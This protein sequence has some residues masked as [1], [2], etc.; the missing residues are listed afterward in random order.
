MH[1]EGSSETPCGNRGEKVKTMRFFQEGPASQDGDPRKTEGDRAG[2]VHGAQPALPSGRTGP[3]GS[4]TAH[5]GSFQPRPLSPSPSRDGG[6]GQPGTRTSPETR[7]ARPHR[8]KLLGYAAWRGAGTY[9]CGAWG[10]GASH[11][12]DGL[13]GRSVPRK[14]RTPTVSTF[15]EETALLGARS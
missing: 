4:S 5:P 2:G 7:P 9:P 1:L 6:Q 15:G 14:P 11:C 12:I 13:G 10:A 3:P 8:G